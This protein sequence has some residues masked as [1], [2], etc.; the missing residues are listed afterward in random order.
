VHLV[1]FTI[2]IYYDAR[3]YGRQMP[4]FVQ[5]QTI[6]GHF[7]EC[8]S[9]SANGVKIRKNIIIIGPLQ[10]AK[11]E[12]TRVGDLFSPSLQATKA[13]RQ[14]RGIAVLCF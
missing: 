13:L 14:S 9:H 12:E 6:H 3:T 2:G 5:L 7:W 4:L 8:S 1:G 10:D 11:A